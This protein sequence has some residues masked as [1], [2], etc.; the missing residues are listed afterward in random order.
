ML[1]RVSMRCSLAVRR[2]V[3][4]VFTS[5]VYSILE[6]SRLSLFP[7]FFYSPHS[8]TQG[9][10]QT[11]TKTQEDLHGHVTLPSSSKHHGPREGEGTSPNDIL[12]F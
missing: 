11:Q 1:C 3:V 9:A 6:H 10:R 12:L 8:E 4:S 5:S 7:S 2:R